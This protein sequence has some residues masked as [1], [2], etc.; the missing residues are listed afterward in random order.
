MRCRKS[1][2][3]RRLPGHLS[4][5]RSKPCRSFARDYLITAY[6]IQEAT[7]P[8]DPKIE[9]RADEPPGPGTDPLDRTSPGPQYQYQAAGMGVAVDVM[10]N[11]PL[12]PPMG[13]QAG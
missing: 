7:L 2:G 4:G 9:G 3:V 13:L 10:E 11:I 5:S 12:Q 1:T 8:A 6:P